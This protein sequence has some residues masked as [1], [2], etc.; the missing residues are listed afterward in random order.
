MSLSVTG[1]VCLCHSCPY[2]GS[3]FPVYDP[4][5]AGVPVRPSAGIWMIGRPDEASAEA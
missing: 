4:A 5:I 3:P 1:P 2:G